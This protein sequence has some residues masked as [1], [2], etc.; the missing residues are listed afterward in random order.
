MSCSTEPQAALVSIED[1]GTIMALTD[2]DKQ[3]VVY[4][5]LTEAFEQTQEVLM[6]VAQYTQPIR[7]VQM[8]YEHPQ[9]IIDLQQQ[10]TD[11]QTKQFLPQ[12]CDHT[13]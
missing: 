9:Q 4:K 5:G 1:Q 8:V 6:R 13:E 10:I 11:L 3:N 2:I 7:E 12:Q